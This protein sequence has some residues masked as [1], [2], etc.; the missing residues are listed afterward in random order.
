M[1]I[2]AFIAECET[3]LEC[4]QPGSLRP[5]TPFRELPGWDSLAALTLL[6]VVDMVYGVQISGEQLRRCRTL[7]E[8]HELTC[9]LKER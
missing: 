3:C 4:A 6:S 9:Q 8:V 7:Q 1:E 2:T 5:D